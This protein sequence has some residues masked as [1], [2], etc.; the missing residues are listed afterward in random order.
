MLYIYSGSGNN[1][2]NNNLVHSGAGYAINL[3]TPSSVSVCDYNNLFS[4]GN[5]IGSWNNSQQY[6]LADYQSASGLEA[7]SV[8]VYPRFTS[9]TDL[10]SDS[11]W[12][13][14]KATVLSRVSSDFDGQARN[15]STP[16]I[17]AD[18]FTPAGG[19]TTALAGTY[20]IGGTSPDYAS[21]A[22]AIDDLLLKGVSDSVIMNIRN[23]SFV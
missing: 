10:H 8:S 4:N 9:A 20:T 18:E 5:Y 6:D 16:D 1:I 15:V 22:E 7:H 2:V 19:T 17:G 21:F 14:G 13:D 3:Y 12:L 23:G 11:P